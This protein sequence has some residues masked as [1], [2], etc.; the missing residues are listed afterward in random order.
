MKKLKH[1]M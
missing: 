1:L